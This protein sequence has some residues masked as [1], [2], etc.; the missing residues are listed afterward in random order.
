MDTS[1]ECWNLDIERELLADAGQC[2]FRFFC[3]H[4]TGLLE[5]PLGR[6]WDED[7]HGPFCDWLG[8]LIEEWLRMKHGPPEDARRF[9]ILID[10]VRGC[11]K[12]MIVS[13]YLPLYLHLRDPDLAEVIDAVHLEFSIE[14]GEMIQTHLS[15]D[16][17]HA[18]FPW[19]YGI[20]KDPRQW[21]KSRFT[22]AARHTPRKDASFMCSSVETGITGKHPDVLIL[23]DPITLEKLRK[24][25]NWIQTAHKHVDSI[26]PALVNHALVIFCATPYEDGDVV[27]RCI[28]RDRVKQVHGYPLHEE[29]QKH[30]DPVKGRWFMFHMPGVD[31]HGKT[32]LPKI[33]PQHEI[34]AFERD[35]PTLFASQILLQP[36]AGEG[37]PVTYDQLLECV[38]PLK[39][40]PRGLPVAITIDTAFKTPDKMGQGDETVFA[41]WGY[42]RPTGD[43]YFLGGW[44]S[45]RWRQ[46]EFFD[47]LIPK[48]EL[49]Q[50]RLLR[51]ILGMTDEKI[52]GGHQATQLWEDRIR[53]EFASA[54]VRCPKLIFLPRG[55][56]KKEAR[57][58]EAAGFIVAGHVKFV[59]HAPGLDPLLSQL[60]RITIAAND[61]WIDVFTDA[62]CPELYR[63]YKDPDRPGAAKQRRFPRRPWDEVL[64]SGHLD[65]ESDRIHYEF[66]NRRRPRHGRPPIGYEEDGQ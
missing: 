65:D 34:D 12:T 7:V 4:V 41:V 36:G 2:D 17:P 56:K 40:V 30:I 24:E 32:L 48:V 5:N 57:H 61:D 16:D 58:V 52:I 59:E 23:D 31:R 8:D 51:K 22:H 64:Q 35:R 55:G 46:E 21:T 1:P 63:P 54:G 27:M 25:G 53:S 29:F 49:Y 15:G 47:E 10:A 33:W 66:W 60:A 9:Y 6:W 50:R 14:I 44:S 38:V 45:N 43:V 39:Q 26:H 42:D 37:I 18:L 19:L 13:T 28:K 11:G 20:W 62:F 3:K